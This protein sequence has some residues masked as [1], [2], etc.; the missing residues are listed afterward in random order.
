MMIKT[1]LIH[2]Q[3]KKEFKV[4]MKIMIRLK[5]KGLIIEMIILTKTNILIKRI[6][7]R[8]KEMN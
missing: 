5:L 8:I 7:L 3:P 4:M 6:P 2:K 1:T